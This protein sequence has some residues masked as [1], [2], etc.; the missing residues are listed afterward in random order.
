MHIQ[1]WAMRHLRSQAQNAEAVQKSRD[2][3]RDNKVDHNSQGNR[4]YCG[5]WRVD[6]HAHQGHV[7]HG[8]VSSLRTSYGAGRW[9]QVDKQ[10]KTYRKEKKGWGY[11]KMRDQ[12][13]FC[14]TYSSHSCRRQ[15]TFFDQTVTCWTTMLI[16]E[17]HRSVPSP[18]KTWKS[19]RWVRVS[20]GQGNAS[21]SQGVKH[22]WRDTLCFPTVVADVILS[23]TSSC[24]EFTISCP[25]NLP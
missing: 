13:W 5:Q 24:R 9:V 15:Q 21:R 1:W 25:Q 2:D 3:T 4:R 20:R 12:D 11:A 10:E 22:P 14:G 17:R 8:T 19:W 16:N 18:R 7:I 6:K 23:H